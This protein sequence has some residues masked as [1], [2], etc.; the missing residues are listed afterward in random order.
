MVQLEEERCSG[1]GRLL[2]Q[3]KS[4]LQVLVEKNP[5]MQVTVN[6]A[7]FVTAAWQPGKLLASPKH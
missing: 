3:L 6:D 5:K 7:G 1:A 2:P 4:R